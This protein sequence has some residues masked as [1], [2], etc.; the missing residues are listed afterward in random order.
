M[1]WRTID[2]HVA[3]RRHVSSSVVLNV[4]SINESHNYN[5]LQIESYLKESLVAMWTDMCT[6]ASV[7]H[8]MLLQ[9][10]TCTK[11][12]PTLCTHVCTLAT[13]CASMC[14]QFAFNWID[15]HNVMLMQQFNHVCVIPCHTDRIR[16]AVCHDV[17]ACSE[18]SIVSAFQM[19]SHRHRID[20]CTSEMYCENRTRTCTTH[21]P[22]P[23]S[24][25]R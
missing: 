20:I 4:L 19:F 6:F 24:P 3:D 25:G 14:C 10:L 13:V 21:A 5:A 8:P 2:K 12:L 11:L 22:S 23:R 17:C 15:L 16:T 9:Q 7:P 1:S 18:C